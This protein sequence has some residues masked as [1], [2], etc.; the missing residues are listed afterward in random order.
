MRVDPIPDNAAAALPIFPLPDVILLPG[1]DLPLNIFEP[2]YIAMVRDALAGNRMIGMIQPCPRVTGE[3]GTVCCA[4]KPFYN[5]GCAGRISSFEE[6]K[7]GRFLITLHGVSRFELE[8]HTLT[9]AGYYQAKVDFKK[10]ADDL[11]EPNALPE[12]MTRH[13]LIEKFQE[14]LERQELHVDWD[15]ADAIPD[16]R[17]YTLLAMICPFTAAEKQALLEA[18]TFEERCRM[19]KCMMEIA[20]AEDN[21]PTQEFPC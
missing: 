19:M 14:Y 2:R 8:T 13:C 5:V 10:Y 11:R 12:C 21:I 18:N 15:L 17:F 20:C 4:A 9:S 16:H 1:G 3:G 6:L 7:D